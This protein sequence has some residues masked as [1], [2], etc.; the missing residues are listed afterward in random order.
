M[1][2][3]ALLFVT[4]GLLGHVA[5]RPS[6]LPSQPAPQSSMVPA[7]HPVYDWLY[8]Q[9]LAGR[10][11]AYAYEMRPMTR[12]TIAAHLARLASRP[13]ELSSG[14]QRLL[15]DF[16]NEFD[17]D[18]L[19]GNRAFTRDFVTDLPSSFV[20]AIRERRDPALYAGYSRDSTLSGALWVAVGAGS[21]SY[22]EGAQAPGAYTTSRAMR[23]FVNTRWGL[24]W[25]LEMDDL[26]T[27][28]DRE[29]VVRHPRYG[30]ELVKASSSSAYQYESFLSFKARWVE[31]SLGRGAQALGPGITDPLV[32]REGAPFLGTFR[33]VL[34]TPRLN[35]TYLHSR[36]YADPVTD[37]SLAYQGR[38]IIRR[39]APERHL[40]QQR[41]NWQPSDRLTLT[42]WQS[43]VY[44]NRGIDLDYLNPA[45]PLVF[46][47]NIG[48]GDTDNLMLG[49]DAVLRP[50]RGTELFGSF[51]VD[52]TRDSWGPF[53][54]AASFGVQQRL[55][56][57]VRVGV[58]YT[59][60]DPWIYTHYMRLN[61]YEDRG[62]FLGPQFGPNTEELSARV[63]AWLPLRTRVMAGV[64]HQKRGLDPVNAVGVPTACV[65]GT[66][67][68]GNA[69]GT[70]QQR[71]LGA[72]INVVRRRELEAY[73]EIIRGLPF[74]FSLRD[75]R[76]VQGAQLVSNR[77]M[78]LR[79]RFGY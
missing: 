41:V 59:M 2:H 76:V 28:G 23:A 31:A 42:A 3:R 62:E 51:L 7:P 75:D 47:Q 74:T 70:V 35:L 69:S 58:G 57:G 17:M 39:T 43:M 49:A 64:R 20:T 22:R 79:F 44:A 56:P 37:T 12:G 54:K 48:K 1:R 72:D 14:E 50:W 34:G 13:A 46:A 67:R 61:A 55:L 10:L 25:H 19:A 24:G 5:L 66:L 45:L 53:E 26:W 63:T 33:L 32:M 40:V 30:G 52:D 77:Y 71:F 73:S 68:C 21:A 6:P 65:G 29:L 11:P 15:R 16:R 18:R 60:I 36:L 78:D 4:Y 38:N 27:G 9:R 8:E